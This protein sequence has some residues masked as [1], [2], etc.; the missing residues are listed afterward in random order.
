MSAG[1]ARQAPHV[2]PGSLAVTILPMSSA[3]KP[4]ATLRSVRAGRSE[5]AMA[6]QGTGPAI[7]FVHGFPFDHS[8]WDE[9]V[10]RF[11]HK[12][13]AIAV[14][15]RG[16]GRSQATS[17]TVT[18]E[19]MAEDLD[20]LLTALAVAEPVVLCGLSMGGYVAFQFW[21]RFRSR[22]RGLVLCD[23]RAVP[24]TSEAAAG[25][26][27]LAE[28]VLAGGS[29]ILADA[30]LPRLFATAT[31]ASRGEIIEAAR[32]TIAAQR[33]EGMAAALRGMA[34]RPD[35]RSYLPEIAV[36]TLVV[37]GQH[38]AISTPDEMQSL[39]G[40]ILQSQFVVIPEAGHMTPVENAAAFDLALEAFLA[41]L[42]ST[43]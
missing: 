3:D 19:Q 28:D 41:A 33:P 11:G 29:G 18:M 16:F 6:E 7:V 34:E 21:R 36:P 40:A 1:T 31:F 27:K 32:V 15:L 8:M 5:L 42:E 12:R 43:R 9:Q 26:L 35:A 22:L 24:D 2:L 4:R 30:M 10:A 25:R 14:D 37:V 17:G 39:A 20:A 13:R 23:T 38:D